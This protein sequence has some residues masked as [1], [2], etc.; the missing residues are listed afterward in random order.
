MLRLALMPVLMP[1]LLL[2]SW[3]RPPGEG[4]P[5]PCV[6][7]RVKRMRVAVYMAVRRAVGTVLV[8]MPAVACQARVLSRV[9]LRLA[10]MLVLMPLLLLPSWACPPG[11]GRPRPCVKH[12][13]KQ[14]RVA[15][16]MAVR[17]AVG[18]VLVVMP[19]VACQARVLSRVVL[20]LAVMPVL[21]PLLLLPSW[22]RPPGEGRPRPCVKHPCV[23]PMLPCPLTPMG[24][25]PPRACWTTTSSTRAQAIRRVRGCAR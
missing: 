11:E 10:L 20:R 13:V 4:R 8:V 25:H 14:V 12:P 19:A 6:K 9:V 16:Y 24:R 18:A 17:R 2:P 22:A 23:R 3:A 21:T 5:R 7:R 1:L 15:V